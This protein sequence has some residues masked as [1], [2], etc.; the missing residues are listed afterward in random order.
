MVLFNS[1]NLWFKYE[2]FHSLWEKAC[3]ASNEY[4]CRGYYWSLVTGYTKVAGRDWSFP[5]ISHGSLSCPAKEGYSV[6]LEKSTMIG[7]P[8][9]FLHFLKAIEISPHEICKFYHHVVRIQEKKKKQQHLACLCLTESKL[10]SRSFIELKVG[11]SAY[12]QHYRAWVSAA[13]LS[14]VQNG[15]LFFASARWAPFTKIGERKPISADW[16]NSVPA[17]SS[18]KT[19]IKKCK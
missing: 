11:L 5:E 13:L 8:C 4:P 6:I 10:S 7:Q 19:D 3:P 1:L 16:K 12:G 15:A 18:L 14:G 9:T 17:E 2:K